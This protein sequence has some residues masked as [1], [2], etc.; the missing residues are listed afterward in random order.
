MNKVNT[1]VGLF[2]YHNE[3]FFS[4][5]GRNNFQ[6]SNILVSPKLS[7]QV[8]KYLHLPKQTFFVLN[9]PFCMNILLISRTNPYCV[10]NQLV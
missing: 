4:N 9:N 5:I 2:H 1:V 8:I 7:L 3:T 6:F 10:L